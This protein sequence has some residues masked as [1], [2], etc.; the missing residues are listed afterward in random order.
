M[1]HIRGAFDKIFDAVAVI[2]WWVCVAVCRLA[3]LR[4]SFFYLL[5]WTV[6]FC[7][8]DW[9]D[10]SLTH[11]SSFDVTTGLLLSQILCAANYTHCQQTVSSILTQTPHRKIWFVDTIRGYVG[12]FQSKTKTIIE[13]NF[14]KRK[15][16]FG[17]IQTTAK[18]RG[19]KYLPI[20]CSPAS[21]IFSFFRNKLP[22]K[23]R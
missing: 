14:V 3:Q 20:D 9:S 11:I 17:I 21:L 22:T 13:R 10:L 5:Y 7:A 6:D 18:L 8:A 1:Q 23:K 12:L 4:D 16:K 15:W 2:L 19:K